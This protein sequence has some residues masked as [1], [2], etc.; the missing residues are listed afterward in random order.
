ML[1]RSF[2]VALEEFIYEHEK[3]LVVAMSIFLS[4]LVSI[5][6]AYLGQRSAEWRVARW[7][8]REKEWLDS[9][10]WDQPEEEL[11]ESLKG[12]PRFPWCP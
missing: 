11:Q 2:D 8:K 6:C 10:D 7:R 3:A 9:I 4:L 1:F 12:G 5:P